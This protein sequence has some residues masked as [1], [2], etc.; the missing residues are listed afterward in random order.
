MSDV[1]LPGK[2]NG[3]SF[4]EE[5]K[6][7]VIIR[8]LDTEQLEKAVAAMYRGGIRLVEVTFDQSEKVSDETTAGYISM[9]CKKFGDRMLIGAGTVMSPEQVRVAAGAG[10]RFIISPDT[11]EPV[12]RETVKLELISIPGVMTA[13]EAANAHRY[14]ADFVKL[15]PAGQFAPSFLRDLCTPLCHVRFLAVGGI[16]PENLREFGAAGAHGYGIS[17][18]IVNKA[19][20]ARGDY[21]L[22]E[23]LARKYVSLL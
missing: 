7:I 21:G 15:F 14:G 3:I 13:T 12:I 8:G 20:V 17:S 2:E 23:E 19:A 10:A 11:Y 5:N 18:G 6:I 4:I 16:T 9:L 22:I 1:I